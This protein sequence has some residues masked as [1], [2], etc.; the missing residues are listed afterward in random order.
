MCAVSSSLR[1]FLPLT[2]LAL[3]RLLD[4]FECI[5]FTSSERLCGWDLSPKSLWDDNRVGFGGGRT[6]SGGFRKGQRLGFRVGK[7]V[8]G[9]FQLVLGKNG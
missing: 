7:R 4:C 9:L 6:V 2:F 3:E 8:L 1:S 5:G